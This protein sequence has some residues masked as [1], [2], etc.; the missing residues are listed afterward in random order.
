MAWDTVPAPN[1]AAFESNAIGN[2]L[3][4]LVGNYQA[5]Q[6]GQQRTRANDLRNQQDQLILDQSKAFAGGVPMTPAG[7]PDW[8]KIGTMEAERGNVNALSAL[9]P[10]IQQEQWEQNR[11]PSSAWGG[12]SS[13]ASAGPE[14]GTSQGP[15]SL[16]QMIQ[17][18][19][20]AGFKGE[21][22]ARIAAI[23]MAE[24]G[25][26]PDATG[27]AGEVGLTQ[28]NPNT[29]SFADSAR[30]PQQAFS[31]AYQVFK[32]QGW[33][34]WSTD[35]TSKNFT[36]GN[37]MDRF[38]PQA[39]ADLGKVGGAQVASLGGSDATAYASPDKPSIPPVS[40]T[41]GSSIPR[42]IAPA[43]AGAVGGSSIATQ[44]TA[45][46]QQLA[47]KNPAWAG[48]NAA[49][50]VGSGAPAQAATAPT[51][52]A[53]AAPSQGSVAAI[54]AQAGIPPQVAAN[55]AAAVRVA[56]NAP[57]TPEQDAKAKLY[58]RNYM[59]RKGQQPPT[60]A[61]APQAP[62]GGQGPASAGGGPGIPQIKLPWG[63]KDPQEA[64]V[65]LDQ[66]A[67]RLASSPNPYNRAQ[68][69]YIEDYRNRIAEQSAPKW[70]SPNERLV[71]PR[72]GQTLI[73]PSSI[74]AL[75]PGAIET[76]AETYYQSGKLPPNLGRG[77]QG[78][79][80][81]AAIIDR[82]AA[83]HPDDPP[84]NWAERQ[85]AFNANAAGERTISTRSANFTAAENAA[86][87]VIPRVRDA[88]KAVNRTQYPS[89]NRIIEMAQVGTGDPA[90]VQFG[91][92]AETLAR[93]YARALSPTGSPTVS[94]YEHGRELLDKAWSQGQIDAA[95]DQMEKEIASE[96][97]SI[98]R[99]RKEF[100][101][102]SLKGDGG[103]AGA[104]QSGGGAA[105][106]PGNYNY[107]P[108]TGNLEPVN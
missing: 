71:D 76:A 29:W 12:S 50:P 9:A 57:L 83:L 66:E 85:Q 22:A 11:A 80:N 62:S 106:P 15:Y 39:E 1:Y 34:A 40:A 47:A 41:A 93:T 103:Q 72:T 19:E 105:H 74:G 38:L 42:A 58:V 52:Q 56:P 27:S 17:M 28:I 31:D 78:P 48:I 53:P 59:Q 21:D 101:M 79:A 30:D 13:A 102:P 61:M 20:N 84:E 98:N 60:A 100:G 24:S 6:Q 82:A 70:V 63:L 67:A 87:S 97:Q 16:S 3:S 86:A 7:T 49:L 95:L 92:A 107:D 108:A 45:I 96:K 44:P 23:A 5:A 73:Q 2:A 75:S 65:R 32:K 55:I 37:S 33:G 8:S 46:P 4:N 51:P 26:K 35:P 10:L 88:S 64:I 69:P 99:T 91:I 54:A 90:M 14:G 89:L 43:A 25:G 104:G 77:V 18:A 68:V 36:P 81:I 94:D